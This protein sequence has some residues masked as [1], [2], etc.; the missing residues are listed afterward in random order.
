MKLEMMDNK[1]Y[2][3]RRINIR[4]NMVGNPKCKNKIFHTD[5]IKE[6][7]DFANSI[8]DMYILNCANE[9][10]E[11]IIDNKHAILLSKNW[12]FA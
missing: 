6:A 12:C 3:G 4:Y 2:K 8:S 9:L 1:C 11:W 5:A 7:M 10:K